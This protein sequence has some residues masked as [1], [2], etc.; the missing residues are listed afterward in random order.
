MGER[1]LLVESPLP[2]GSSGLALLRQTPS[3]FPQPVTPCC[4]LLLMVLLFLASNV[5][6]DAPE[7]LAP[8]P[9]STELRASFQLDPFYV[10]VIDAEG[11]PV[12]GSAK[13]S[14]A[15]LAECA[16]IVRHMLLS[17]P[18]VLKA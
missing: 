4:A 18:D 8:V 6:A 16:W 3:A 15:A 5:V 7:N 2:H 10:K 17:R 9:I 11:M 14:D 12:V 13:V 1:P